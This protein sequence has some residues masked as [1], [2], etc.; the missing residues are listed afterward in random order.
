MTKANKELQLAIDLIYEEFGS[1]EKPS[2]IPY[3]ECCMDEDEISILL[4]TNLK[5]LSAKELEKYTRK[6][7][8][9]VGDVSDLQY[10]LPRILEILAN[11]EGMTDYEI[12]LEKLELANWKS[13]TVKQRQCVENLLIEIWKQALETEFSDINSWL[14]A[15][16]QCFEDLDPFLEMIKA[17]SLLIE[18]YEWNSESLLKGKLSSGFWENRPIQMKQVA[19]WLT[20][21]ETQKRITIA[22]G[23]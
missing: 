22:Y 6:L 23:L 13:W 5:E 21:E 11:N 3:C 4:N 20:S 16:G 19:D 9:T 7:L 10:F 15:L 1:C 17:D 2:F 12:V 14:C 18:V 8:F